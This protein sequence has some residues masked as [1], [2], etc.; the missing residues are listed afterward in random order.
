[1]RFSCLRIYCTSK[2]CWYEQR[3]LYSIR[4]FDITN[5]VCSNKNIYTYYVGYLKLKKYFSLIY[6]YKCMYFTLHRL[7]GTAFSTATETC[8]NCV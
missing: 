6:T 4:K 8:Q 7:L 5:F 1:M 2:Y 3:T